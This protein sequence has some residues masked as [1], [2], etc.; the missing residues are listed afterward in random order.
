M[1]NKTLKS[2]KIIAQGD[3][4]NNDKQCGNCK[5]WKNDYKHREANIKDGQCM[6][7]YIKSIF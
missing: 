7:N 5:Y 1:G 6:N 2:N 4:M 3:I